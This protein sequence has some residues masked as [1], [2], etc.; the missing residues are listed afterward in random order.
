MENLIDKTKDK[1]KIRKIKNS[2]ICI[3]G[4]ILLSI[5]IA[6]VIVAAYVS[7][8][9]NDF[10]EVLYNTSIK[11][12]VVSAVFSIILVIDGFSMKKN[13][14]TYYKYRVVTGI[15]FFC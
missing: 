5:S 3:P 9:G 10:F 4:I 12:A 1:N 14:L 15:V 8:S 11:S 6:C 2:K 13:F 7:F